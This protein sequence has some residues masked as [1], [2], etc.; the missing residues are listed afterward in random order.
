MPVSLRIASPSVFLI[1]HICRLHEIKVK[2]EDLDGCYWSFSLDTD[3]H[4]E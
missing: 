2:K 4:Y 3:V 1:V